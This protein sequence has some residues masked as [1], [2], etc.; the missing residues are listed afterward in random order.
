MTKTTEL[1]ERYVAAWNS[2][3]PGDVVARFA[4]GG[5]YEDATTGGPVEG[6]AIADAFGQ[7]LLAF[8]DLGFEAEDVL[9]G[10][11]SCAIQW[12]MRGTNTGSFSGAPPTGQTVSLL[13]AQFLRT[14]DDLVT[15]AVG[16][17]DQRTLATGLGLQA[18]IMPR[19]VGPIRF[20]TSARLDT[21]SRA[22]PGAIS[23][24]RIDVGFPAELLRLRA[25]ARPVLAGMARMESVIGAAVYND[26]QGV[27]YTVSGWSSPE[28]AT[29]MMGQDQHRGAVR[30]FFSEG[31]GLSAWTS[32]WVPSRL[33]TLWVRCPA[34]QKM[35]DADA[36]ATCA[37]GASLPEAPPYF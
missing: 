9:A 25:H 33:N 27:A 13:G 21:G 14:K 11:G 8:P 12:L 18:P 24:T 3:D 1:A 32:V 7:L 16:Y 36:G 2:R 4:A 28:A 6:Q 31:L 37:C 20:G 23:F 34:C 26:G 22:R 5:T 17:L 35:A 29:E 19:R 15:S 10:E 30:A